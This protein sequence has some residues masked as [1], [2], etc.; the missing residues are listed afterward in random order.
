[1]ADEE[2]E[3]TAK[4]QVTVEVSGR[5]ATLEDLRGALDTMR[6]EGVPGGTPFETFQQHSQARKAAHEGLPDRP[7][8]WEWRLSAERPS[9]APADTWATLEAATAA[10]RRDVRAVVST[11]ELLRV[12]AALQ[13]QSQRDREHSAYWKAR[14]GDLDAVDAWLGSLVDSLEAAGRG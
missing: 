2:R 8:Q 9:R 6:L 11:E 10:A 14:P 1:V 12:I 3:R 4:T 13:G 7:E 5:P